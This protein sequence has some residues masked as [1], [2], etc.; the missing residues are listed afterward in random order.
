[1]EPLIALAFSHAIKPVS[2]DYERS[3]DDF[4]DL[5]RSRSLMSLEWVHE[6]YEGADHT[7]V[8]IRSQLD[9]LYFLFPGIVQDSDRAR[10]VF[11]NR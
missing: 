10:S 1:M 3:I 7:D 6:V 11:S 5:L 2:G 9:E 8:P 4:I